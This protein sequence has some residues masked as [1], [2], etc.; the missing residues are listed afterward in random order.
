MEVQKIVLNVFIGCINGRLPHLS[1]ENKNGLHFSTTGVAFFI[2]FLIFRYYTLRY[3]PM[4]GA[5]SGKEDSSGSSARLLQ[6]SQLS[7]PAV[8]VIA[9]TTDI[10]LTLRAHA[11]KG[12]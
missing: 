8:P 6:W 12:A 7:V 2:F 1:A 10:T 11:E 9:L 4:E 5:C 3:K